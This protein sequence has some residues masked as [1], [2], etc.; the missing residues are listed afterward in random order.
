MN[1]ANHAAY[2]EN[3]SGGKGT[4]GQARL[5]VSKV[6]PALGSRR[7]KNKGGINYTNGKTT[8]GQRWRER[9]LIVNKN[10]PEVTGLVV[11]S[12]LSNKAERP[13]QGRSTEKIQ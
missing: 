8:A 11:G 3:W 10:S 12:K 5:E 2:S 9:K 6:S 1:I 13:K 7:K 4:P